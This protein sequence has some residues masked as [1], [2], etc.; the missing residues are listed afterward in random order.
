MEKLK[1]V[2]F[3]K[4]TLLPYITY[5]NYNFFLNSFFVL[6]FPLIDQIET[7]VAIYK[8]I[9]LRF[10]YSTCLILSNGQFYIPKT[11][12]IQIKKL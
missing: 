7:C 10:W 12:N 3:Y 5:A 9:S 2:V 6:T 8:L 1:I 4:M 11:P